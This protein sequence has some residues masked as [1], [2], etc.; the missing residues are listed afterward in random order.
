LRSGCG[1]ARVVFRGS[2]PIVCKETNQG[3]ETMFN[4]VDAKL[5]NMRKSVS[6][7]VCP[8][9]TGGD[10]SLVMIQSDKRICQFDPK[11]GNGMLSSGKGGH[12]GFHMLMRSCGAKPVSVPQDVIDA[13]LVNQPKSGDVIHG[14]VT[15]A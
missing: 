14:I 13:A 3:E 12:P 6:W 5:G 1:L 11:T 10:D 2:A 4:S 7:T 9:P 15:I 8:T